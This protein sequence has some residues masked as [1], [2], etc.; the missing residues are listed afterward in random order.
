MPTSGGIKRSFNCV[1][2]SADKTFVYVGTSAGEMM[3]YRRDTC[4]FR[5]V[6]PVCTNGLQ[7]FQRDIT[8]SY[9]QLLLCICIKNDIQICMYVCVLE[10]L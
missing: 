2:N 4:V 5:A 3:I 9:I 1:D 8:T 6:I 10:L 7:V